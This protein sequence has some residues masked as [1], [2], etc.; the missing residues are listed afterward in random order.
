MRQDARSTF[1]CE[2]TLHGPESPKAPR[3][4]EERL[5]AAGATRVS[6]VVAA[7]PAA[8]D[9][10]G[11]DPVELTTLAVTSAGTLVMIIDTIRRWLADGRRAAA[12]PEPPPTPRVTAITLTLDGDS[13]HIQEPLTS[14]E[15]RLIQLFAERHTA[16][17]LPPAEQ[18]AAEDA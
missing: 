15:E 6:L 17:G 10:R 3:E 5:R 7:L 16:R 12:A 1:D 18:P 14:T 2:L 11:A 8:P 13:L 4:L 9:L